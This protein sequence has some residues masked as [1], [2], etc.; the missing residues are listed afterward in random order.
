MHFSSKKRDKYEK[1][2]VRLKI[3]SSNLWN[4]PINFHEQNIS[5]VSRTISSFI[6]IYVYIKFGQIGLKIIIENRFLTTRR[7]KYS[8]K[9]VATQQLYSDWR[10]ISHWRWVAAEVFG[11][12]WDCLTWKT[13]CPRSTYLILKRLILKTFFLP[14]D[15]RATLEIYTTHAYTYPKLELVLPLVSFPF[16]ALPFTSNS[17][18][19][20]FLS[21]R[22]FFEF[23][24]VFLSFNATIFHPPCICSSLNQLSSPVD[25]NFTS[26]LFDSSLEINPGNRTFSIRPFHRITLYSFLHRYNF[27]SI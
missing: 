25:I 14:P 7:V 13:R 27:E 1:T 18:L 17:P 16:F 15:S 21:T 11:N 20:S 12:S 2:L 22:R 3:I 24:L 19:C 6:Y 5:V 10:K 4:L 9:C 23:T 8:W 26:Y